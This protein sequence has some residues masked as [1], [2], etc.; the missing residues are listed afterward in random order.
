[1]SLDPSR[2]SV[3]VDGKDV[4]TAFAPHLT[5]IEV[6]DQAGAASD[7]ATLEFDDSDG[8][9][10]FP[11]S[12]AALAIKLVDDAGL[13]QVF[14]GT[15]DEV[16]STGSRGSGR[17]LHITAKGA[18]TGAPLKEGRE[19]HWD[20][21]TLGKVLDDA[22]KAHGL[23]SAKVDPSLASIQVDYVAQQG[24]SLLSFGQRLAR[25]HGGT[26]R[27]SGKVAVMDRRGHIPR[28]QPPAL[29][30]HASSPPQPQGCGLAIRVRADVDQKEPGPPHAPF[31]ASSRRCGDGPGAGGRIGVQAPIGPGDGDDR[32]RHVRPPGGD[33]LRPGR[34]PGR[35]R[36]LSDRRGDAHLHARRGLHDGLAAARA[37]RRSRGRHARG[38]M[39]S[40]FK[41]ASFTK[42]GQVNAAGRPLYSADR[43]FE[44]DIGYLGSGL[45]VEVEAGFLTDLASL[46]RASLWL[47]GSYV[48]AL[49][50][51]AAIHDK[52][53]ADARFGLTDGNA[54]FLCAMADAGLP[55]WVRWTCFLGVS[56]NRDRRT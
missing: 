39:T 23:D 26:F 9:I 14:R 16:K 31:R 43:S 1:M 11:R 18:D 51:P 55:V 45:A 40:S 52:L 48:D 49:A 6:Q 17:D 36:R 2:F 20:N 8:A 30:D 42:T 24:E 13:G 33:V 53:R 19:R 15:V 50:T 22:A 32:R 35:R 3:S 34:P 38:H 7:S 47:L 4:T 12:G 44:Y 54:V 21:A 46:P 29:R 10:V 41:A 56:T 25:E 28:G 5:S 37:P 27:V